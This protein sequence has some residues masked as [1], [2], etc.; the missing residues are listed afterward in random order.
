MGALRS[1]RRNRADPPRLLTLSFPEKSKIRNLQKITIRVIIT[2]IS[3]SKGT[4]HL[5]MDINM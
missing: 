3:R 2:A 1:P 5:S 4:F